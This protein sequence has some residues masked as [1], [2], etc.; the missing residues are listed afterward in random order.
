LQQS[1]FIKIQV[2]TPETNQPVV[3]FLMKKQFYTDRKEHLYT[4]TQQEVILTKEL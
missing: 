3:Q 4:P 1:I 2:D